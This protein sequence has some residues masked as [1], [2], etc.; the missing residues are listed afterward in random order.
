M[1]YLTMLL[2]VT[3]L[4]PTF[5]I[6]GMSFFVNK[7]DRMYIILLLCS[8]LLVLA[9]SMYI[10]DYLFDKHVRE[11]SDI[12]ILLYENEAPGENEIPKDLDHL[13]KDHSDQEK[14]LEFED[15]TEE[16]DRRVNSR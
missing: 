6:M 14:L 9:I 1:H 10:F 7:E 13:K 16:D 2:F 4:V 11:R 15:L 5:I 8:Y 12:K 3:L